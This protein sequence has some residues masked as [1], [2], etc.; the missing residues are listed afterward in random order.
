MK[1]YIAIGNL[2]LLVFYYLGNKLP[3]QNGNVL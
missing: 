3:V 1:M 2:I